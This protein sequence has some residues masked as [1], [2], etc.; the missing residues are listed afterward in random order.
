MPSIEISRAEQN[1]C[2]TEWNFDVPWTD[3]AVSATNLVCIKTIDQ[4]GLERTISGLKRVQV[5]EDGEPINT[6][7]VSW[8]DQDLL[9]STKEP[10]VLPD[11]NIE[12]E[13]LE[14]S[15]DASTHHLVQCLEDGRPSDGPSYITEVSRIDHDLLLSTNESI[16]QPDEIIE[17]ELLESSDDAP[18]HHLVQVLEDGVPSNTLE[19]SWTDHDLLHS[20]NKPFELPDENIE[21]ELLD[22]SGALTHDSDQR[23]EDSE[24]CSIINGP[25]GRQNEAMINSLRT[26]LRQTK[27]KLFVCNQTSSRRLVANKKLRKDNADLKKQLKMAKSIKSQ[28]EKLGLKARENPIIH[29]TLR[30]AAKKPRGRRYHA[31]TMKFAAGTYITGARTYRYI[32]STTRL[33][34]PHKNSIY[35]YNKHIRI[36]PGINKHLLMKAKQKVKRFKQEKDRLVVISCDGMSIRQ[37]LSYSAKADE[38]HGFECDGSY[39]KCEK[40]NPTKL[41]SEAVAVMVNGLYKPFKQPIGYMLV[42][43]SPGSDHQWEFIT[44]CVR[45]VRK[46]GL[47]PLVLTMDQCSTNVKM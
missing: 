40:N 41:A 9:H 43:N 45:E 13:L 11:E 46:I 31:E 2:P 21:V 10:I 42:H 33:T 3:Q 25:S 12:L 38:F 1:D 47:I 28:N 20:T 34:L 4:A 27:R 22:S 37:D 14:S 26:D 6:L 32:Q 29:D 24:P 7:E 35:N 44:A 5:L 15:D 8:I 36:G 18:I 16:G 39:R 23:L 17:L 19:V 30:N